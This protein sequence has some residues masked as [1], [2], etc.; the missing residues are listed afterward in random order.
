VANAEGKAV[1][2]NITGFGDHIADTTLILDVGDHPFITKRS[3]VYYEKAALLDV[4]AIEKALTNPKIRNDW[5][6]HD[7]CS[8]DLLARIR[9]GLITS[10]HTKTAIKNLCGV[11][12]GM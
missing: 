4:V 12:W 9:Q 2:V 5:Q 8:L 6:R 1:C 3:V 7:S 10:K 11:L